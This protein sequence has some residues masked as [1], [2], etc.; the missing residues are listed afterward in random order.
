MAKKA[1]TLEAFKEKQIRKQKRHK[2]F[3]TIFMKTCA[4]FLSCA[5]VFCVTAF[6]YAHIEFIKG[7]A[8]NSA[9]AAE[10]EDEVDID[11]DAP[12]TESTDPEN[13]N[14][15]SENGDESNELAT[16]RAQ[17]EYFINSFKKVKTD[18]KSAEKY[19]KNDTNYNGV[20]EA[21]AGL[22]GLAHSLMNSNM[23]SGDVTDEK[24]TGDDID[25]NFPPKGNVPFNFG[26]DDVKSIK[27]EDSG[28]YYIITIVCKGGVNL[29]NGSGM[30]AVSS[31]LTRDQIYDPIAN[32]PVINNIG[33]PTCTYDSGTC[34]AKIEKETGHLVDYYT[35]VP[36]YLA[37]EK[38]N[39][40][41]GLRFE[42]RW[43]IEY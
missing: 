7:Y 12:Q 33:D 10:I 30:G 14:Q 20:V 28:D 16:P 22:S 43:R 34:V 2:T 39:I 3:M 4:A 26:T 6:T 18:A 17:L 40:R 27:L 31:L 38:V 25:N 42:E 5:I 23:E 36:L 1:I 41:V 19:W 29:K 32:I 37:F 24:Y 35:D 8:P 21:P 11:W 13:E 15:G 9:V